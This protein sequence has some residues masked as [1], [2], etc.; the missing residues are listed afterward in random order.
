[1]AK[2]WD[3]CLST[4]NNLLLDFPIPPTNESPT[5][6]IDFLLDELPIKNPNSK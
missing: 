1:M 5:T 6:N 4:A 2:T 3:V